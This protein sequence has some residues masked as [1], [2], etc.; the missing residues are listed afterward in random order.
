MLY[1]SAYSAFQ[2]LVRSEA[3]HYHPATGV[4]IGR[5]KALTADFGD[6]RGTFNFENPLTGQ[7]EEH[8][9]IHGHYFDTEAAQEREGWTDEERESVEAALDKLAREQPYLVAKI[10]FEQPKAPKSWP[11]YDEMSPSDVARLAVTMGLS[12]QALA[13][14]RE[15]LNREDVIKKIEDAAPKQEPLAAVAAAEEAPITL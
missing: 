4:E 8:A 15:N 11:T 5:T 2:M 12:E 13:Y 14:E 3:V 6:H 10:E 9:M 1:K 7:N